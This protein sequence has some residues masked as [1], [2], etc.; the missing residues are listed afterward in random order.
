MKL[1]CTTFTALLFSA[2]LYGQGIK[3]DYT[4][5]WKR[6]AGYED[7][8]LPASALSAT[9]S[10]ISLAKA[11]KNSPQLLKG[12][13]YR[14][15]FLMQKDQN[16]F[17][18]E[19]QAMENYTATDDN[20]V[21]KAVLHSLLAKIYMQYF[22]QNQYT[23]DGRTILKGEKPEDIKE[24]SSNNFADTVTYHIQASLEN[25]TQLQ[26]VPATI[27]AAI[28]ET[29]KD[30]QQLQ[31]TLFDFLCARGVE[32]LATLNHPDDN[33]CN[34]TLMNRLFEDVNRFV[35]QE[36]LNQPNKT[37]IL[38]IY[39][40]W[41]AFRIKEKN[42]PALI[43]NDLKRLE[44]VFENNCSPQKNQLYLH[45]LNQL[46]QKHIS[47]EEVLEVIAAIANYYLSN[48]PNED[49]NSSVASSNQKKLAY[50]LCREGITRFPKSKKTDILRSIIQNITLRDIHVNNPG[51]IASGQ[52]VK[53]GLSATNAPELILKLYKIATNSVDY[54]SS[55][56]NGD[57]NRLTK[58]TQL[59]RTKK[60]TIDTKDDFQPKDTTIN[61]TDLEYG[62]YEYSISEPG[63]TDKDK[64]TIGRFIVSDFCYFI[65]SKTIGKTDVYVVNRVS[66]HPVA[67]ATI[68]IYKKSIYTSDKQIKFAG[69]ATTNEQGYCE[70]AE[71]N[72]S[73]LLIQP[74]SQNDRYYPI[75]D[76]NAYQPA[77][78][79]SDNNDPK[80]TLF[81]DRAIYR[82]GQTV[83]Y[84]GITWTSNKDSAHV[85]VGKDYRVT[86]KDA[87]NQEINSNTH[88]SNAFGSFFG[89]F[90]L[91]RGK[92]NGSFS[93]QL[94]NQTSVFFRVEEYKRPGF[95]IKYDTIKGTPSF[96]TQTHITGDIM[97]YAGFPI[98]NA[99]IKYRIVRRPH[100]L[101]RWGNFNEQEI[102]NGEVKTNQNGKFEIT[103]VPQKKDNT[104][105]ERK[106]FYSYSV[107]V[108]ATDSNGE[109]QSNEMSFVIGDESM[110]LSADTKEDYDKTTPI[111]IDINAFNINGKAISANIDYSI[112]FIK[113]STE[114]AENIINEK[115]EIEQVVQKGS[116]NTS[117][118]GKLTLQSPAQW[119]SG[120]YILT[121][122]AKDENGNV[123]KTEK[124]FNLYSLSDTTAPI[125]TYCWLKEVK[126]ICLPG[127]TAE[128]VFGTSAPD[129]K[130]LYELMSGNNLL[131]SRWTNYD[132]RIS[133]IKIPFK[134]E[135]KDGIT[136]IL[137]FVK[138]Q[139]YFSRKIWFSRK[140]EEKQLTPKF[141]VFRN[142]LLPGQKEE[143]TITIPELKQSSK[144]AECMVTMYDASLDIFG[145][146]NW[147]FT[148][149]N[150]LYI[151]QS[152]FWKFLLGTSFGNSAS[153][154]TP[155]KTYDIYENLLDNFISLN[156]GYAFSRRPMK[157]RGAR[158]LSDEVFSVVEEMPTFDAM[159]AKSAVLASP[160]PPPPPPT[161]NQVVAIGYAVAQQKES[162]TP[163]LPRSNFSETAFFY[164]QL[165][166]D[167]KGEVAFTFT[168]PES[169][170]RWNV[171]GLAHTKDLYFGQWS[172]HTVT[173]KPF[174]VQPNLPRFVREGDRL[175]VTAK[176]INLSDTLQTGTACLELTDPET[177][178]PLAISDA[179]RSF[180]IEKGE[181]KTETWAFPGF[182]NRQMLICKI[183]ASTGE[184]S[185]GE[186]H[187]IPVLPSKIRITETLPIRIRGNQTKRYSFDRLLAEGN[188]VDSKSLT[189][190]LTANPAWY[191]VL[192][193]PALALPDNDCS[194]SWFSSYY[195][196]SLAGAI[197]RANPQIENIYRQW[198]AS[199]DGLKSNLEKNEEVKDLLLSET[200]WVMEAKNESEQK[201][202]IS[203]LF[204]TNRQSDNRRQA[205]EKLAS[206]QLDNG[207]FTWFKGMYEDRFLTQ[208]IAEGMARLQ[209]MGAETPDKNE[210]EMIRKA[211]GYADQQIARDFADLKRYDK[212]WQQLKSLSASQI[213]YF[214]MRSSY[215]NIPIAANAAEA[216]DFYKKRLSSSWTGCTLFGQALIA[217]TA[218][219]NGNKQL[220]AD[221]A[222][223]LEENATVSDEKG[224]YWANNRGG[225]WWHESDIA[226]QTAILEALATINADTKQT[227]DMKLWLLSQKQTERWHS[228][229]ATADA[230]Y[231]LLLGG[232][233]WLSGN[234][235]ITLKLGN[236]VVKSETKEAGTGC[237]RQTFQSNDIRPDMA[238]ITLE[239]HASHPAWGAIY[240]QYETSIDNVTA[241]KGAQ[242]NIAKKLYIERASPAGPALEPVSASTPLKAGDKV[243]VRLTVNTDRDMEYVALTD[244][245]AACLEPTEPLSEFRWKERIGYYQS[246]KDAST[247]F[248]FANLPKGTY[249]FEYSA[250]ITRSG[251]YI[252]GIA[253]IQCQYAPEFAAHTASE[254]LTIK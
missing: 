254:N 15:R 128:V 80:I 88:K 4:Q 116:L 108:D 238:K 71:D 5:L 235:D 81:T 243:T 244:Q 140:K 196:N 83:Y 180:T 14:F 132:N 35:S 23:I 62:I 252:N 131:E 31:P 159:K 51:V 216:V 93:L 239:N 223:S 179:T 8:R 186:Q 39:R 217:V 230:V 101:M 113:P 204:D 142:K 151:V 144:Q 199:A 57:N 29:G 191:G 150:T 177:G 85:I 221:I 77:I 100:W 48:E 25:A 92:L 205:I 24:W 13:I 67:G 37:N 114:Y 112:S 73:T 247:Q 65:R 160:P 241:Q 20:Q 183:T 236:T 222:R 110:Y 45:S 197:V 220:A 218:Q 33:G 59:I 99:L 52:P 76:L 164:P 145:Q 175:V 194:V 168:V 40:Q 176:L 141:T 9:D 117:K 149:Q 253:T 49:D 240:W 138:D 3:T 127:D 200:P 182:N 124:K 106:Q 248:F 119:K 56:I 10:L 87:N 38:N 189:A 166:T 107:A 224:M 95:E 133:H 192:A 79:Q 90:S 152:P 18:S 143:W 174:M 94:E 214:Y 104:S 181:N 82:P 173:Q 229:I 123:I 28:M 169:L 36:N 50:A 69:T 193:L 19:L 126:D 75:E 154:C 198:Q 171:M 225:I 207:A 21:E 86:L 105:L 163:I 78:E 226:T 64:F 215:N 97:S 122:A 32:T 7:K 195:A 184:F 115:T 203:E 153:Y 209:K 30:S 11:Q 246:T 26:S 208:Y 170:T 251:T 233:D 157:N 72:T 12:W 96:G 234:N 91:P 17:F 98:D 102:A 135:W 53:I 74:Q 70:L 2:I 211:V 245:R 147:S 219:R 60:I 118:K 242:L 121:A 41:L 46:Y 232:S 202:R 89:S 206:L 139:K 156:A 103:F 84:K 212:N 111:N 187:Y 130:V 167:E 66:G 44:Y 22:R 213:Y 190:E 231:A 227:D 136:L 43:Y 188:K 210:Q 146:H 137:S 6:I 155:N 61:L 54:R 162:S 201:Q 120:K 237:F 68:N 161:G 125:K 172:A 47:N 109:T 228:P 249:V 148:P 34:E 63:I 165:H 16:S 178:Q 55:M 134:G 42:E 250:W 129:T 1:L 158:S 58:G 27:Y 185:D